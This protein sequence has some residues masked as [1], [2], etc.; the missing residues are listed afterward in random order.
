[1]T[2]RGVST[3]R[4]RC[5]RPTGREWE[6]RLAGRVIVG[7]PKPCLGFAWHGFPVCALAPVVRSWSRVEERVS[8]C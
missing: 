8:E 2:G 7:D 4:V 3:V 1:M 5:L 6:T